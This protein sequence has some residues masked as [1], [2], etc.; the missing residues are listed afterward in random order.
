MNTLNKSAAKLMINRLPKG[1]IF[2]VSFIKA[3]GSVRDMTCRQGVA[4]YVKGTGRENT[5]PNLIRVFEMNTDREG[6][7]NYRCF[8]VDRLLQI[9]TGGE[10]FEIK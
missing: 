3:D 4:K 6:A 7:S 2:S 1:S 8:K 9:R 5:D 10:T